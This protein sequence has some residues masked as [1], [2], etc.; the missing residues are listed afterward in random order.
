MSLSPAFLQPYYEPGVVGLSLVVAVFASYVALDLA[1]RVA[2]HDRSLRVVWIGG[3]GLVMGSGIWAM[4]F[5]GMLAFHLPVPVGYLA[6]MTLLSWIAAVA[7]S[8][9]ALLVAARD[10]L[11][12]PSLCIGALAMG[13]GICVMHYVGMMALDMAPGIEWDWRIV[14][15]SAVIAVTASAVALLIFFGLRRYSGL[16]ARAA[17]FGA[18]V[19]MGAAISGMHYTGMA[20]ARFPVGSVCRS[21]DGLAGPSLA[22]LVLIATGVLLTISLFTSLVDS[23]MQARTEELAKSLQAT[24]REL[25]EANAELQ[26]LAHTDALTGIPNLALFE[27]RLKHALARA[28]RQPR[29]KVGLMFV[30]LDG[31]KLVNDSRGHADGDALLRQV[32]LRMRSVCRDVDTIARIGGDEFIMLLEGVGGV[33]E[34]AAVAQRIVDAVALPFSV[35]GSE[36]TV[37]AS[38]GF[39]VYPDHGE[40]GRLKAMADAAMYAAKRAGGNRV[41]EFQARHHSTQANFDLL[42]EL[43]HAV[44]QDQLVLMYQPKVDARSGQVRS[45]EALVRWRHPTRGLLPPSQFISLAERNGLIVPIGNWVLDEACRQIAAWCDQGRRL[46]VSINL[47]AWQVRQSDFIE[48]VRGA[49][50]RHRADPTLLVC[51]FTESVAMEDAHAA[52]QVID[53]LVSMGVQLSFDDFGTG[54]S[55]LAVLRQLR[56]QELKID[57]LFVCDIVHDVRA[58]EMVEAVLKLA[59][60][61]GLKVVAEGVETREQRDLLVAMGCDELQGFYFARPMTP[62]ALDAHALSDEGNEPMPFSPSV[63]ME[64]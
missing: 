21:L 19:I 38:V 56:V 33:P 37:T 6:G 22:T 51:E 62:E 24:H 32:A 11:T 61:L 44:E 39:A 31:F 34:A 3:G 9:T 42:Q 47:S 8:L 35:S 49:L 36:I 7:V 28:A 12:P 16:A 23:R 29:E 17:Q 20:A 26:R 18:A 57:R 30:D 54:Y 27:T 4:H 2:G 41:V 43:R 59:H 40:A 58:R 15:L 14:A 46:R 5:V 53:T 63:L 60:A 64:I 52:Q 25:V 48:H 55:S 1:R 10:R 13:V 45:V 50:E